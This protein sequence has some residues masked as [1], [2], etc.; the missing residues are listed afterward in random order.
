MAVDDAG[1]RRRSWCRSIARSILGPPVQK[2]NKRTDRLVSAEIGAQHVDQ[3]L[4]RHSLLRR[5]RALIG[6]DNVEADMVLEQFDDEAIHRPSTCNES[7]QHGRALCPF[8]ERPFN[9]VHLPADSAD[10]IEKLLLVM[11]R[12]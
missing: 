1:P 3:L 9:R 10:P 12:M 8:F 6:I 5:S 7:L 2:K 11:A 4:R